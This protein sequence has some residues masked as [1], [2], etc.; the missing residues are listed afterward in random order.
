MGRAKPRVS[1]G[2]PV[3]NG[4]NYVREA[5][6]S[7]L[8]QTYDNFELVISDNA[9]S[10]GTREVCESYAARDRR[11]RYC[12]TE[13]NLG[14]ANNFNRVF[15][16][17]SGEYFKWAAH[18]DL[19]APEYLAKCVAVLDRDP[20]VVLCYPRAIVID[21]E[22]NRVEEYG[23]KLRTDSSK[24][25]ERFLD[26]IWANHRCYQ[27]FGVGRASALQ[28]TALMGNYAAADRVLL[29]RLALLGRFHEI[30]EGLFFPRRHPAQ[31]MRSRRDRHSQT[32]WFDSARA[33]KILF[34]KWRIL[35]G[36]W[37]ALAG[38]PLG[39]RERAWC[40]AHMLRWT[41]HNARQLLGDV[42][43]AGKRLL[44][45]SRLLREVAAGAKRRNVFR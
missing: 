37:G 24:A 45:R 5:I 30:P 16:R 19:L 22:G 17:S 42:T 14:A 2:M 13:R 31:F 11:V 3:Y 39:W 28:L 33:G 44:R 21:E 15:A 38:V 43:G 20:S 41:G 32:E 25:Q 29:A 6:D 35:R 40:C 36:Y 18:D 12:R 27:V 4:E 1:I 10:D 8:R 26:L 9:S 23:V 7:I 34:P